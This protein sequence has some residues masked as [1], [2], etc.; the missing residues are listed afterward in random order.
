MK[1]NPQNMT[2]EQQAIEHL[3]YATHELLKVCAELYNAED[4]RIVAAYDHLN[5]ANG[6]LGVMKHRAQEQEE[7]ER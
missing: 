1:T 5:E 2:L 6:R 3:L 4:A 7:A